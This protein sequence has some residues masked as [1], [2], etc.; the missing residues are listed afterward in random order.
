M[1]NVAEWPFQSADKFRAGVCHKPGVQLRTE[2]VNAWIGTW[3]VMKLSDS[4][5]RSYHDWSDH[6]YYHMVWLRVQQRQT[7]QCQPHSSWVI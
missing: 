5:G 2:V 7:R 4:R 1:A 3:Q 6:E